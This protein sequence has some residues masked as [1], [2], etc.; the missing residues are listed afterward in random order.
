M[1]SVTDK[2]SLAA[3]I[4]GIGRFDAQ[5]ESIVYLLQKLQQ[6][7]G[8]VRWSI[9]YAAPLETPANPDGAGCTAKAEALVELTTA[10]WQRRNHAE[11]EGFDE[12]D[13]M[14]QSILTALLPL[15]QIALGGKVFAED[16]EPVPR[17]LL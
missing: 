9:H 7:A 15:L 4:N 1:L 8:D 10:N 16:P 13:A 11:A 12:S 3:L 5:C 17:D 6:K 2:K 14:L